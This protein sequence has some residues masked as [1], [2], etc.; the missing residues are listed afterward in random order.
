MFGGQTVGGMKSGVSLVNCLASPM[1]GRTVLL[2]HVK[3]WQLKNIWQKFLHQKDFLIVTTV[4]FDTRFDEMYGACSESRA[5]TPTEW[6][7]HH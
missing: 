6:D 5:D 3:L 4:N 7:R 2:K 1:G